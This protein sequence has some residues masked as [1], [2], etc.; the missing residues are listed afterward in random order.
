MNITRILA[1]GNSHPKKLFLIDGLGAL[2]SAVLLGI[3]LVRLE[4]VFGIPQPTLYFLASLP[5]L[6]AIFDFYCYLKLKENFGKFL[7]MIAFAHLQYCCL[8]IGL[9]IFHREQVTIL[10]W[11]YILG[12]SLIVGAL[13]I[14]ELRVARS[15]SGR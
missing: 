1:W 15:Q 14:F 10:G 9:M 8:S 5:C 11:I 2:L 13:A 6:F 12:E 7:R 4:S 3:V